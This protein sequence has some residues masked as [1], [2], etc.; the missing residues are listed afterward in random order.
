[1]AKLFSE[2]ELRGVLIFL[3][4][5]G[6]FVVGIFLVSRR[7]S[8]GAAREAEAKMKPQTVVADTLRLVPFDPNEVEYEELL[9]FGIPKKAAVG[10]IRYRE[11]GKVYRIPEDVALCYEISDSLYQ[12]LKPYIRIGSQYAPQPRREYVPWERKD[13]ESIPLSPFRVDTVGAEYLRATLGWT[14]KQAAAFLQWRRINDPR[15]Q[16]ELAECFLLRDSLAEVIAPYVIFPEGKPDLL[17]RPLEINRAD[18]AAL[19]SVVGIGE[20]TVMAILRYR[21][22]LGGFYSVEQL[23]EVRGVMESNYEKILQ[24]IYC[25]SCEIRKIDIN[26]AASQELT[27]HPYIEPKA[28]RRLLNRRQLKGGWSTAEEFLK[29][30]ILK[31]EEAARLVPYL[32]FGMVSGQTENSEID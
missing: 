3:P 6:L 7:S 23:A 14:Y 8:E 22:R 27:G 30:D 26:F 20:K 29:D 31:P 12:C 18:S 13:E 17:L 1:M 5:A 15:S 24:Q 16:Q 11:F 19:R 21:D 32:R 25:D 10:L 9:T 2:L 4:L 28:L